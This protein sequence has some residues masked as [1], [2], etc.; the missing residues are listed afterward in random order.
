MSDPY[1]LGADFFRWEIATAIA[2]AVTESIPVA[3][4]PRFD[5]LT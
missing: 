3:L 5:T 2:G 1:D 4:S